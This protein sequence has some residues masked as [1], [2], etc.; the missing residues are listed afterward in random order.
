[1]VHD[2]TASAKE[3]NEDLN[4]INNWTFSWKLNFNPDL[5][6]QVQK[7]LIS[8]KLQKVSHLKLILTV[9]MF[10]KQI[11]KNILEWY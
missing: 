11:F 7:A 8:R 2:I 10:C 6:K 1:M 5:S 3:L 9:K 4:K